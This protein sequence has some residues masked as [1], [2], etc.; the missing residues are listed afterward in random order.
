MQDL[1]R[2]LLARMGE[3]P[4]RE[5][6]R[7]TPA[8]MQKALEYFTAGYRVDIG[9]LFHGA[10]FEEPCDEM[11]L[12]KDIEIYSLCEHHILPFYGKCHVAYIPARKLLGLSKM[13]RVVEA[14]ARR[15]QVQERMTLQVAQAIQQHLEPQGVG[16][17]IEAQHLCMM[18][19]GVEKQNSRAIT[20]ATLGAMRDDPKSRAEFLNLVHGRGSSP[21]F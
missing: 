5:G 20:S 14:F 21:A 1:I 18:M 9:S 3:D 2:E 16:V 4:D 13:A 8:R 6:L 10:T 12:V 19:R 11:V 15:L 17:I 7:R